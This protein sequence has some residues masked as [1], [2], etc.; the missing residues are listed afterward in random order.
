[1]DDESIRLCVFGGCLATAAI[2]SAYQTRRGNYH[3]M[4]ELYEEGEIDQEPTFWNSGKL[5]KKY[6]NHVNEDYIKHW[7]LEQI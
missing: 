5:F 2:T 6:R 1:M 3:Y 4:L 7:P